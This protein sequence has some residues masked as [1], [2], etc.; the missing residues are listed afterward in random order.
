MT[1]RLKIR[2]VTV[3]DYVQWKPLWDGYNE[4]YGRSGET[5]L[6][7]AITQS[8]W[9]RFLDMNEPVHCLVAQSDGS[10]CGLAHFLYHRNTTLIEQSCY[11]QDLFTDKSARGKGVG[12]A[13]IEAVSKHATEN[14]SNAIYWHT[15]ETNHTAMKLYDKVADAT[16]FVMYKK[17]AEI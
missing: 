6:D 7:D 3:N 4:F 11:M 17:S 14:G 5:T 1:V 2:P 16:G 15:H 9:A 13:L 10:L 8:T 12:R